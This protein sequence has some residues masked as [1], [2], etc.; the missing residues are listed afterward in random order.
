MGANCDLGHPIA[1]QPLGTTTSRY[2]VQQD[3]EANPV[4]S[5]KRLFQV[6]KLWYR[7]EKPDCAAYVV[8]D[9]APPA[10]C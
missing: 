9:D 3:V 4:L 10:V 1:S 2:A 8:D 7:N 5:K 6:N